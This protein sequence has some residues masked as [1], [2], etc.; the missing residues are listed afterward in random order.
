[1][2]VRV[3]CKVRLV[4]PHR[5]GE[6]GKRLQP[7]AEQRDQRQ[8]ALDAIA[9]DA[10]VV[11]HRDIGI[12]LDDEHRDNVQLLR[13]GLE[14]QER[15]VECREIFSRHAASVRSGASGGNIP[16]T[17]RDGEN[18]SVPCANA[19]DRRRLRVAARRALAPAPA[20]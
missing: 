9:R 12:T 17:V 8:T 13:F 15:R 10:V 19:T 18:Y 1:M 11:F 16:G 3:D 4:F 7:P 2:Q 5:V 6:P 14:G 20:M